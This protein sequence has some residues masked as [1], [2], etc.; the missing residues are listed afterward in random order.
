MNRT[1]AIE[2][3]QPC[4]GTPSSVPI[5]AASQPQVDAAA[6]PEPSIE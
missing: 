1:D 2:N 4:R 6:V 3:G 5:I